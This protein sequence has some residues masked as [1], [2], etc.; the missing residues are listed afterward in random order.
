M[1]S[2][3]VANVYVKIL[4]NVTGIIT[5]VKK[6]KFSKRLWAAS[7]ECDYCKIQFYLSQFHLSAFF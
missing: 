1:V 5:P 6:S 4:K 2:V 7:I 3:L